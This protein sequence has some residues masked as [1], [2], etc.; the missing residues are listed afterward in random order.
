[1]F[2]YGIAVSC[3]VVLNFVGMIGDKDAIVIRQNKVTP[4]S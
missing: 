2:V 4:I 1:M 3:N